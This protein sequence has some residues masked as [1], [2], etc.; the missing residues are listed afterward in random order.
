MK[1]CLTVPIKVPLKEIFPVDLF[2]TIEDVTMRDY[3]HVAFGNLKKHIIK[4]FCSPNYKV[5]EIALMIKYAF[6]SEPQ[7]YYKVF[8]EYM[9]YLVNEFQEKSM[10]EREINSFAE[11]VRTTFSSLSVEARAM[12]L[13]QSLKQ[14]KNIDMRNSLIAAL[15]KNIERKKNII[16]KEQQEELQGVFMRIRK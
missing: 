2:I 10:T 15:E 3:Y 1:Q 14:I 6:G 4:L 8:E 12:K 9:K 13:E 16:N 7:F 5:N 11:K